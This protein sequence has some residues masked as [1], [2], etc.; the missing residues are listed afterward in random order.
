MVQCNPT[1][2]RNMLSNLSNV[3]VS[4]FHPQPSKPKGGLTSSTWRGISG[5]RNNFS[6]FMNQ[7]RASSASPLWICEAHPEYCPEMLSNTFVCLKV[8]FYLKCS[9]E[10]AVS[11]HHNETKSVVVSQQCCQSLWVEKKNKAGGLSQIISRKYEELTS[12]ELDPKPHLYGTCCHKGR[13]RCWWVW[14]ARSRY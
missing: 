12:G 2:C 14:K 7:Y 11:I 1:R 10:R 9:K 13:A 8:L 6:R 3:V 4:L 5:F